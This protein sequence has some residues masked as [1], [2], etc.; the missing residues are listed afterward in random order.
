MRYGDPARAAHL[1]D[2]L[3]ARQNPDGG[4]QWSEH[5]A[6]DAFAT[7]EALYVLT[8]A[9]VKNDTPAIQKAWR[10]PTVNDPPQAAA[11]P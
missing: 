1:K 2:E 7:G 5:R 10:L 9:G 6:S 4:W 11:R 3:L 8:L